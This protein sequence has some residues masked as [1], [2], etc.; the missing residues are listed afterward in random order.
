MKFFIFFY[1]YIFKTSSNVQRRDVLRSLAADGYPLWL[2]QYRNASEEI[3]QSMD[4]GELGTMKKVMDSLTGEN[5]EQETILPAA[6]GEDGQQEIPADAEK[7]F[8][9]SGWEHVSE[10]I[11]ELPDLGDQKQNF[12]LLRVPR[13]RR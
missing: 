5:R 7:V 4:A 11:G 2:A 9:R 13:S 12:F 1:K 6:G 10:W 3:A 8:E